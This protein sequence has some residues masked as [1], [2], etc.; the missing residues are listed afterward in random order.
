MKTCITLQLRTPT[1]NDSYLFHFQSLSLLSSYFLWCAIR[2]PKTL[3]G[4]TCRHLLNIV[5]LYLKCD[6][7]H[8]YNIST[9]CNTRLAVFGPF[10]C[11]IVVILTS[12]IPTFQ[13]TFPVMPSI[14]YGWHG[15]KDFG[16]YHLQFPGFKTNF[17]AI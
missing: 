3:T 17:K 8:T 7:I 10:S 15:L 4:L 9:Q 12:I 2:N 13:A 16:L 14:H 5:A 11:T 6:I 1:P